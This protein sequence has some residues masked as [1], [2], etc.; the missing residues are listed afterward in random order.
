MAKI[1]VNVDNE[2]KEMTVAVNGKVLEDVSEVCF[3]KSPMGYDGKEHYLQINI[4]MNKDT[5]DGL[6]QSTQLYSYGSE[7]AESA[8]KTGGKMSKEVGGFVEIISLE[9][10]VIKE[11]QNFLRPNG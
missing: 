8:L 10:T 7:K 5:E 1:V 6:K 2:T 11:I 3:Y 4:R 9:N